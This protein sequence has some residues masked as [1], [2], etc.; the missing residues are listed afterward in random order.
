MSGSITEMLEDIASCS[1]AGPGVTRLPFTPEHNAAAAKIK[2]WMKDTNLNIHI[3]AA[4][5]I[6]GTREGPA[7]SPVL[8]FGSHQDSVRNGGKY[9]GIMGILLP[10]LALRKIEKMQLSY[11]VQVM[12]FA[13]E[14][15]VR[16]PTALIGPRALAGN[17]D[18]AVLDL[19]DQDGI[20]IHDAM[21]DFGLNPNEISSLDLRNTKIMGYVETHIEQGPVLDNENVPLGIVTAISGIERY[22][23]H[24]SGSA[25]HAG[26]VPMSGRRDT[27]AC[28]AELLLAAE[29]I[30]GETTG[31]IATIGKLDVLPNA[32]NVIPGEISMV[33]EVRSAEDKKREQGSKTIIDKMKEIAASRNIDFTC[34]KTYFQPATPCDEDLKILLKKAV[35]AVNCHPIE[36][37]S[38]ATHDASAMAE[39]CPMA[40]LFVRCHQGISHTPEEFAKEADMQAAVDSLVNLLKLLN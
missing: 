12:A 30:A 8:L 14:E 10:I 26:T 19:M 13:D 34:R 31:L 23:I 40:M 6:I 2:E 1:G 35:S 38:G 15:G 32:V 21:V 20:S 28:A 22:Q 37:P 18:P 33:L 5:T 27:L 39:L 36:L 29:R 3:D 16:F 11:S 9:D 24:L 25:G 4:G 7:D 17:F